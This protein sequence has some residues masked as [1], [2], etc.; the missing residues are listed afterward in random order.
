MNL[1]RFHAFVFF[2]ECGIRLQTFRNAVDCVCVSCFNFVKLN[3]GKLWKT[4]VWDYF[5]FMQQRKRFLSVKCIY[6]STVGALRYF[7]LGTFQRETLYFLLHTLILQL[8]VTSYVRM[9]YSMDD[10]HSFCNHLL[11]REGFC[12]KQ[13]MKRNSTFNSSSFNKNTLIEKQIKKK[14]INL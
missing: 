6:L 11:Q 1:P 9:I 3:L 2:S 4:S 8:T 10:V 12:A 14:K 7:L 13:K 5:V